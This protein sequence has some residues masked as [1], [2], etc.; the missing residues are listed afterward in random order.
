M[1]E[2]I[3]WNLVFNCFIAI[4]AILNPVGNV[5]VFLEYVSNEPLKVQR[6]TGLLMGVAV[7]VILL[8]FYLL[9]KSVLGAFGITIP[10]FRIAGGV[11]ILLVGLRMMQGQSKFSNEGIETTSGANYFEAAKNKMGRILVPVAMPLFVGPGTIT[12]TILYADKAEGMTFFV[13]PLVLLVCS[14][15]TS[16]CLFFS[17]YLQ[18]A[19]GK[20]G[21]QIVV[22]FM[23]LILC[24]IAIQ[25][26]IDGVAQLLPNVLNPEFIHTTH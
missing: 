9:G 26:M 19:L 21:M 23:G 3:E 15:I 7:F 20:N 17:S 11:M 12:T 5:A 13:L 2:H 18:Q 22:R 16:I 10:A 6:A 25:F 24:S 1:F 4:V 14:L 8:L